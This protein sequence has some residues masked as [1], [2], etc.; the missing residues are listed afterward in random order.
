MHLAMMNPFMFLYAF[1]LFFV[2]TP[3]VL[4]Y[5]PPKSGK[6]TVALTHALV[7][8]AIWT[9][10]HKMVWQATNGLLEGMH[11]A[12]APKPAHA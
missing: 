12:A 10:T 11:V 2:L 7:F 9:L 3:G 4:V 6:M 8:A 5:L 1:V